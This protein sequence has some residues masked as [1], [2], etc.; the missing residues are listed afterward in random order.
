MIEGHHKCRITVIATPSHRKYPQMKCKV[1]TP[2]TSNSI[3]DIFVA[4]LGLAERETRI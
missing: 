1:T 4:K 3:L 2:T